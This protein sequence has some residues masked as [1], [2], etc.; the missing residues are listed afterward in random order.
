VVGQGAVNAIINTILA[1]FVVQRLGFTEFIRLPLANGM[2]IALAF[3]LIHVVFRGFF[4]K[5]KIQRGGFDGRV[6]LHELLFTSTTL[7]LGAVIGMFTIYLLQRGI[8]VIDFGNTTRLAVLGQTVLYLL[9]FDLYFY[10]V[11]RVL[12]V[13]IVYDWV[14]KVHHRSMMPNPLTAFSV[15]PIEALLTG[16]FLPLALTLLHFHLY[17]VALVSLHGTVN[18]IFLHTGHEVFPRWWY[19]NRLSRWFVTPSFHDAH[20]SEIAGNYGIIT[21]IWDRVFGTIQPHFER[22]FATVRPHALGATAG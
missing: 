10:S 12:H 17:A 3:V 11:H 16:G 13:G 4:R 15:H 14:H 8:A 22:A 2:V 9:L 21:T 1:L 5:R 19:T 18:S 20:H 7:M 6:L